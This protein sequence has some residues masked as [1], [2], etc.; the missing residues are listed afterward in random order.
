MH[1]GD[2]QQPPRTG[3]GD[4]AKRGGGVFD[5][6]RAVIEAARKDRRS[7]NP[8]EVRLWQALKAR[9]GGFKFRRQH[10]IG[11]YRLD[12]TCLSQRLAIEVDGSIHDSLHQIAHDVSR[13]GDLAE[14]GFT[15]IRFAA[16]D[17]FGNLDGVVTAIVAACGKGPLHQ[18]ALGPPPRSGEVFA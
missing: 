17:V 16:R 10:P 6:S 14:R 2:E 9:P 1:E 8:A 15:T 7:G 11:P 5:T 3:E 18:A 4:R 13:D 12:F